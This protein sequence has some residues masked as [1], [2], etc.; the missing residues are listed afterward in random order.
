[1]K[2]KLVLIAFFALS[3][4]RAYGTPALPI[5]DYANLDCPTE[6]QF[7]IWASAVNLK[8]EEGP[9]L[10][11]SCEGAS[12]KVLISKMFRQM[13]NFKFSI[14]S[15]WPETLRTDL[16]DSFD[17]LRRHSKKLTVDLSQRDSLA[18]NKVTE[19]EIFLSQR[20][21]DLSPLDAI[22]VLVHEARHSNLDA[23][24][25]VRCDAGDIPQTDGACDY[26]FSLTDESAG[27]YAYGTLFSA[28]L[29]L[30]GEGLAESDREFA[31]SDALQQVGARFNVIPEALASKVDVLAV[32]TTDSRIK[33][34]HPLSKS[35]EEIE[36][37][38]DGSDETPERIEFAPRH[39]G[40]LITTNLG[41]LWTWSKR[42]GLNRFFETT[43]SDSTNV[44]DVARLR[45]PFDGSTK[46]VFRTEANELNVIEYSPDE[47]THIARPYP[48]F[49]R[50][51]AAG[52]IPNLH[53]M[54]LGLMNESVYLGQNGDIFLA[55]H[56]GSE[57]PFQLLPQLQSNDR[58]VGGTGGVL[59]DSL[60]LINSHGQ[61][62]QV[63]REYR[64]VPSNNADDWNV[65]SVYRSEPA[66]FASSFQ[67]RKFAQGLR[68]KAILDRSDTLTFWKHGTSSPKRFDVG[69][70]VKDFVLMQVSETRGLVGAPKILRTEFHDRCGAAT[71]IADPWHGRDLG[72][73]KNGSV[74]Y[75]GSSGECLRHAFAGFTPYY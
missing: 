68:V 66:S 49:S 58:W 46:Y 2:I 6:E 72:L 23:P 75:P 28:A 51:G 64:D 17:F 25:H 39:N 14:P 21:F 63:L 33:I 3:F 35:S 45:V 8:I 10:N 34:V 40:L 57:D 20:F 56:Y 13:T 37:G 30:Y 47:N 52:V 69:Y 4:A 43:I 67:A 18:Y 48:L 74:V 19:Q 61:I 65:E 59:Y 7:Q 5:N 53:R 27:A 38:F 9:S 41:R 62:H 15:S 12:H 73:D 22:A 50:A 71:P 31:M 54:F 60:F 16:N 42:E 44:L 36:L 32:L 24:G 29:A 26:E 1:M 11:D 70:P 55:H